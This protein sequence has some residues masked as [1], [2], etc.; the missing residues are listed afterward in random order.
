MF[1]HYIQ[2]SLLVLGTGALNLRQ[3]IAETCSAEGPSQWLSEDN[4]GMI[5]GEKPCSEE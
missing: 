4:S 2:A 3:D 5:N 1:K